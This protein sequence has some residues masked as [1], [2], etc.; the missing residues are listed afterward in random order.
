MVWRAERHMGRWL[1]MGWVLIWLVEWC[2]ERW[3]VMGVGLVGWMAGLGLDNGWLDRTDDGFTDPKIQHAFPNLRISALPFFRQELL[4]SS[5]PLLL[6]LFQG[7]AQILCH[8]LRPPWP[9]ASLSLQT[10]QEALLV[11]LTLY[12]IFCSLW[13]WSF[14]LPKETRSSLRAGT[15]LHSSQYE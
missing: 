5:S 12:L 8:L 3:L 7:S 4:P 14:Y 11:P 1:E 2:V 13:P 9:K 10:D 15:V 6:L